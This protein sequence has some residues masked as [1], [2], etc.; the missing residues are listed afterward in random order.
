M[1]DIPTPYNQYAEEFILAS[2]FLDDRVVGD[3]ISSG[4]SEDTFHESI[5][6]DVWRIVKQ[7][8]AEGVLF[9]EVGVAQELKEKYDYAEPMAVV[10]QISKAAETTISTPKYIKVCIDTERRRK[11]LRAA[12]EC[13]ESVRKEGDPDEIQEKLSK[14]MQDSSQ[15]TIS[16]ADIPTVTQKVIEDIQ[17]RNTQKLKFIGVST[18]FPLL[19]HILTGFRPQ[20]MNI[21]AGRAKGGKSSFMIQLA[22]NMAFQNLPLR[23]WTLEMS[24]EQ[25]LA[26]MVAN[27]SE[28][29]AGRAR[30]GLLTQQDFET[31][32]RARY[33]LSNKQIFITDTANV[34]VDR[35]AAQHRRDI[36]KYGQCV[37]FI[38]YLQLIKSSDRKLSREQQVS[39]ISR[40]L[41]L[42]FKET[43]SVGIVL[44]QLNRE[45]EKVEPNKSHLRESGSLEQDSDS[46]IFLWGDGDLK[47]GANRHGAE[48]KMKMNFLRNI[49]K[50]TQQH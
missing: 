48:G 35:I 25:L 4:V 32:Q 6:Q 24:E 47:V 49:S 20:S 9:D 39:T 40:D 36:A 28:V 12:T 26:K 27:I 31:M 50:F 44:C 46:I 11:L 3:L 42:L 19:D 21:I 10:N 29:D 8:Y 33:Q 18:G 41:K 15:D 17:I 37:C 43:N 5:H 30:D 23:I 7:Y 13:V 16:D 45:A 38:D 14:S 22:I 1:I 2:T 34:T